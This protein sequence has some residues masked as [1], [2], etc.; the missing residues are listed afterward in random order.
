MMGFKNRWWASKRTYAHQWDGVLLA[1]E[2]MKAPG[3]FLG[4]AGQPLGPEYGGS[5]GG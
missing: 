1:V 3:P 4:E 2:L 5:I